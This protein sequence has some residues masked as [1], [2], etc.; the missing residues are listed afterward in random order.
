M[1]EFAEA[2]ENDGRK[3]EQDL[4]AFVQSTFASLLPEAVAKDAD[5]LQL[6]TSCSSAA[7]ALRHLRRFKLLG[8]SFDSVNE[9]LDLLWASER[10]RLDSYL[11]V[12]AFDGVP[13]DKERA[14]MCV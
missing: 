13:S 2:S 8:L 10:S 9:L 7:E 1:E 12:I 14:G 5:A 11:P 6:R 3:N 4:L